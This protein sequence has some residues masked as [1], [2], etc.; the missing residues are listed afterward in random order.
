MHP[1][2]ARDLDQPAAPSVQDAQ[3]RLPP[4]AEIGQR[5]THKDNLWRRWESHAACPVPVLSPFPVVVPAPVPAIIRALAAAAVPEQLE[6][7]PQ[8]LVAAL[9]VEQRVELVHHHQRH[10]AGQRVRQ[11]EAAGAR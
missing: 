2:A 8:L 10:A 7:R 5:G 9:A 1:P 3:L 4:A 6:H 11:V